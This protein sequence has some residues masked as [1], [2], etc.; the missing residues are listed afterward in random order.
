[1]VPI[2]YNFRNLVVRKATTIA[3]AGGLALV[4]FVFASA[5]MLG[6]GIRRTLGRSAQPDVAVILRKG[7][8]AELSSSIDEEAVSLLKSKPEVARTGQG[9]PIGVGELLVV[10]ILPKIGTEGGV[11]NVQVRGVPDDVFEFR[12]DARIVEGRPARPGTDEVV[13]GKGIRGRFEGLEMGRTFELRK[14]RPVTVVGVFEDGASSHESEVWA[15]LHKVRAAFGRGGIVSAVRVRLTSPDR[16]DAYEQSIE[17]D[18]QLG[19]D[20]MRETTY[21]EKQSEALSLFVTGLGTVIAFFFAIGAM[22]GA[23]ITMHAS[24]AHRRREIGTL[25]ALGFSRASILFSFLVESTL[26]A[27]AGGAVGAAASLLMGFVRFSTMNFSSWS[28]IVFTF[29]PTPGTIV[30]SLI[31]AGVMGIVGGF[32][33]AL[34][35]ARLSP[36]QAMRA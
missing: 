31:F 26:L 5:S 3:T 11:S 27:L 17:Q 18:R 6:E 30:G 15:D 1:M 24:V 33:P 13:I 9:Q 22:I 8:D 20:V 4:V 12:K 36:V 28:E 25:R 32:L 16:F 35:A 19:L 14:N 10:I 2:A 23:M 7:A 34:K 29:D 21:Y